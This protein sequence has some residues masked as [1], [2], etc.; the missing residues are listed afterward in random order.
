MD[1][2]R[3]GRCGDE[4]L[5]LDPDGSASSVTG[6][7][8]F[9]RLMVPVFVDP[10]AAVRTAREALAWVDAHSRGDVVDCVVLYSAKA[11]LP[12][13]RWD[14]AR[15]LLTSLAAR[16]ELAEDLWAYS[17]AG[18]ITES[19]IRGEAVDA[20]VRAKVLVAGLPAF[21][22]R[23]VDTVS[24]SLL[25]I[26]EVGNG[27]ADRGRHSLGAAAADIRRRYTHIP[28][29]WGVPVTAA[30]AILAIEG[31]DVE[32]M[33]LLVAVGAHGRSW[34]ARQEGIFFLHRK[35]GGHV[36]DRLGPEATAQAWAD[37]EAM[38][39]EEMHAAVDALAA[40]R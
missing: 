5:T 15:D 6:L 24:R 32:A 22:G 17:R 30:G 10:A 35:F 9:L 39:V 29:A 40:E 26:A 23:H 11:F 38:T 2:A 12:D 37:G 20:L 31:R 34:Q 19:L 27:N 25:A 4:V 7:G 33:R 36:A 14:D 21:P 3:I 16:D 8:W 18:L 13:R 1:G 28:G